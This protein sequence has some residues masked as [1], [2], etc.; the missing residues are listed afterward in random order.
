MNRKAGKK[1]LRLNCL[2][3]DRK[4]RDYYER[5]GFP[6]KGDVAEPRVEAGLY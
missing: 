4:F 3:E 6:F 2:A 5:A 1:F